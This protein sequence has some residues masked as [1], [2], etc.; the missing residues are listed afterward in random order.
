MI[1]VTATMKVK[2]GNKNVF[3]SEA[4]DLISET[5]KEDGCISYNLLAD[6]E[7]ENV[8]VMLEQWKD[9]N[10]LNKHMETEHFKQLEM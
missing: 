3:I 4:Q 6:T 2:P 9:L 10:S 1:I 7:D 8:L 5:R